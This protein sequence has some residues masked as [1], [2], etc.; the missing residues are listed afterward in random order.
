MDYLQAYTHNKNKSMYIRE[1]CELT[2]LTFIFTVKFVSS[3][4]LLTYIHVFL[5]YTI[6]RPDDGPKKGMTHAVLLKK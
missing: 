3:K 6:C 4:N 2:N 1:F 5:L